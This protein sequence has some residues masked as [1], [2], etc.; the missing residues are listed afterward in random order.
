MDQPAPEITKDTKL[1][2]IDVES[3]GLHGEA[4]AVGAVLIQADGKVLDDFLGRCPIEGEVDSWVK[5][6]IIKPLKGVVEN[7]DS[8]L[9]MRDAFWEWYR[10]AK[11]QADYVLVDN[12][13]PVEARFLLQCQADD[14]EGRYW[15][16]PYPLLDLSAL[17][18]AVG[19]KPL[20]VKWQ[21]VEDRV[22]QGAI[23]HHPRFDAQVSAL[24]AFKAL[25]LA[26]KTQP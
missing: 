2:S 26:A 14:L 16:H 12:G 10:A 15:D 24:A 21:W 7:Y 5:K 8:S 9:K 3:N 13:Y 18:L 4:F 17:L 6:N 25:E 1:L 22:P 23:R 11:E 20:A 19:V